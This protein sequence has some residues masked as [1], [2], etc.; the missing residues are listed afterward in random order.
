MYYD[1]I[2]LVVVFVVGNILW[3]VMYWWSACL[4]DGIPYNILCF[5]VFY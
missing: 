2:C 4:Q 1:G 5:T 3:E